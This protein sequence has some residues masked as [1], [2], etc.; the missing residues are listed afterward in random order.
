[1]TVRPTNLLLVEDD[2][3]VRDAAVL[4]MEG[5][6]HCVRACGSGV[7]AIEA[8]EVGL[9][10]LVLTDLH[11]PD[12]NGLEL[13]RRLRAEGVEAPVVVFTGRGTVE[14]AVDAI[15]EGAFH[16]L[17]K[18]VDPNL[19]RATVEAALALAPAGRELRRRRTQTLPG[20]VVESTAMREVMRL[21]ERVAPAKASV[22]VTGESGTGK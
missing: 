20:L 11:M 3:D 8:L 17:R 21:V 13:L 5:W 14:G 15:R 19:L 7:A 9:P 22:V 4:L 2:A 6:G 16:F 10:D 18:P 1:M 12:M